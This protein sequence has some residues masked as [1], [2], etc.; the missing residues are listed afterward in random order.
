M[1]RISLGL[2]GLFVSVLL[3]ARALD[4]LP[5]PDAAAVARRV[6]VCESLAVECSL[7]VQHDDQGRVEEYMRAVTGRHDEVVSAGVRLADGRLAFAVGD[8][9][10]AWAGADPEKSTP[11]HMFA[12]IARDGEPWGKVELCYKSLPYSGVWWY[13]GGGM[14]PLIVFTAGV[15]FVATALYLRHTF[16]KIE[17]EDLAVVPDGVRRALNTL[18]E[19][20]LVLDRRQQIVL[21]N[22]G[23]AEMSGQAEGA[24]VGKRAGDLKWAATADGDYPWVK[25]LRDGSQ[26]TGVIL[27]LDRAGRQRTVSVNSSPIVGRDGKRLGALATFNDLTPVQARNA[28]LRKLLLR[29]RRSRKKIRSQAVELKRAKEAAEAANRAKG[30]FL[31]NVSH[32]IRTPMNAIIGMTEIVLEGRLT[33]EQRE[34]LGIVGTSAEAL[35]GVI[36][37]LLDLSKIEAG[38]FD[39]DPTDFDL[40]AAIDDTLQTLALRAHKKGLE[41]TAL[42]HRD[43]PNGLVGDPVRLRQVLVNLVGNAIKFTDAGEVRIEVWV[44]GREDDDVGLH[45]AVTDTGIGVPTDKLRAIFEPFVQAD[46]GT[47]RKYGGTGLGLTITR[48]LVGL[49]GGSV[50]AE[51]RVRSGSTFHFTARFGVTGRADTL[52]DCAMVAAPGAAALVVDDHPTARLAVRGLLE[53]LTIAPREA[54]G[55][56]EAAAALEVAAATGEPYPLVL[57]DAGLPDG[58]GFV[59]AE[60][61][62]RRPELAG[63]V[64]MM[65]PVSDLSRDIERC[66]AAGLRAFVRKPVRQA[67]LVRA[68]QK[69]TDPSRPSE[70]VTQPQQRVVADPVPGVRPLRIL[71]AEDNPFNQKVA[72]LKLTKAGHTVRTAGTGTEALAAVQEERFDLL[73]TDVQMPDMD[74]YELTTAVRRLEPELRY[75]LPIVALTAH[76][77][78]G[79]RERFLAA[80]MDGY[81]TK[82]IRDEDLWEAIREV[83]GPA[84]PPDAAAPDAADDGAVLDEA[85]ALARVGGDMAT[86]GELIEVFHHDCAAL[87]AE[88]DAAVDAGDFR[89]VRVAAHTLKGMVAFFAADRAAA[90]ALRV[91]RSADAGDR[92][93]MASAAGTLKREIAAMVAVLH[94]PATAAR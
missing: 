54:D 17:V 41:L 49:M 8:H 56:E 72:R 58:R 28:R 12:A 61:V 77:M 83:V 80:G 42:V 20:V 22:N 66:R 94:P 37:D 32:E 14:L 65:L 40:R 50:W 62:T 57:I 1:T 39:L 16:R 70:T 3:L 60:Q 92:S 44:E 69:A 4:L 79:D 68:I 67:D 87:T 2:A 30:E 55:T 29:L 25:V 71:L 91:E 64:V 85:A 82:P 27:K 33:D 52:V 11:T 38:K 63:A 81:V 23:F 19:G 34:C 43:V 13:V 89:R 45:F 75:R 78:K 86:F 7:A 15:G 21:A 6:T 9:D 36:N 93:A 84:A 48:H 35:L 59:L 53:G 76:A 18:A 74:G 51:S 73:L 46:G 47:T 90:A 88:M 10:A 5:D 26:Q 24:V 31:A